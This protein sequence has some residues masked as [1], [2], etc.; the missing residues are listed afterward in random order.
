MPQGIIIKSGKNPRVVWD[1]STKHTPMDVVINDI[2]P[3]DDKVVIAFG[4][5]KK[6]FYKDLYNLCRSYP[7]KHIYLATQMSKLALDL[8]ESIQTLL[9]TLDYGR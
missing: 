9:V 2:T 6:K 8:K 3:I 1:G 7:N 4:K 5:V